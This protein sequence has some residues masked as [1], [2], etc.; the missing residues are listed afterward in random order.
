MQPT[1]ESEKVGKLVDLIVERYHEIESTL[2][3]LSRELTHSER[4]ALKVV[5]AKKRVTIG[6]IGSA[7][8]APPSTTTWLVGGLVDR[9]IFKREQDGKDR[10]KVWIELAEKG[11]SLARLME[12]IPD[13]IAADILY[14]L[15]PGQREAFTALVDTALSRI[16]GQGD[17]K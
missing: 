10:R 1:R 17:V 6:G 9:M 7:L 11:E 2:P 14:K 12:R 15:E 16:T 4:K 8:G 3:L 13:R 5:A